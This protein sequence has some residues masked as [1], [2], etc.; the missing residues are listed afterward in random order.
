MKKE[1]TLSENLFD[2]IKIFVLVIIAS[3]PMTTVLIASTASKNYPSYINWI[4]AFMIIA[5]IS[6][7][8]RLLLNYYKNISGMSLHSFSKKDIL[9][10]IL[11]LVAF[12]VIFRV[13]SLAN[14]I[15]FHNSSSSNDKI[16]FDMINNISLEYFIVF[17]LS[18]VV[19]APFMEEL[20]FRGIFT[21]LFFQNKYKTLTIIISS[22]G[23]ALIHGFDNIISFTIYFL[24][25]LT[26]YLAYKRRWNLADSI[27]VHALNNSI[28]AVILTLIYFNIV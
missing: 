28:G 18:L 24:M 1:K 5:F 21:S 13:L 9:M 12:R 14:S 4:I 25:G 15:I 10:D 26:L 3:L 7:I 11:Y 2:L 19:F 27:L 17:I 6:L 20:I 16:L 23:F 8:I 22:I